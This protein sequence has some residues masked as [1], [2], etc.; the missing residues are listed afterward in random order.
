MLLLHIFI[1]VTFSYSFL[2]HVF[3]L[4]HYCVIAVYTY[5]VFP[6]CRLCILGCTFSCSLG[7][8]LFRFCV[9]THYQF[10][11]TLLRQF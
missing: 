3:S 9:F 10:N 6:A 5:A 1:S 8:E 4:L 11:I 2:F 7:A